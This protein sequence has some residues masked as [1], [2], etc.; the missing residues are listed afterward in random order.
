MQ[1]LEDMKPVDVRRSAERGTRIAIGLRDDN[2]E[3]RFRYRQSVFSVAVRSGYR[4]A[5]D[6]AQSLAIGNFTMDEAMQHVRK[7]FAEIKNEIKDRVL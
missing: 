4:A 3:K 7:V 5:A 2:A 6:H 1:Y